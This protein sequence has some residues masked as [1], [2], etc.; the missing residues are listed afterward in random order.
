MDFMDHIIPGLNIRKI[1][2]LLTLVFTM[3]SLA[4]LHAINIIFRQKQPISIPKAE[5]VVQIAKH[6]ID[7]AGLQPFLRVNTLKAVIMQIFCKATGL[8]AAGHHNHRR[9]IL[10]QPIMQILY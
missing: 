8:N 6:H 2:Q 10:R 7:L 3:Q 1:L 9:Y 4:L 5:A